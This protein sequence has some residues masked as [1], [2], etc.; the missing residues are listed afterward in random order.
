VVRVLGESGRELLRRDRESAWRLQRVLLSRLCQGAEIPEEAIG[1]WGG[2]GGKILYVMAA[3]GRIHYDCKQT[4][5]RSA[6][7]I[8][9]LKNQLQTYSAIRFNNF[10][11][12]TPRIFVTQFAASPT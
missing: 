4:N 11:L 6:I 3:S 2:G 9:F 1:I 8:P 7:T 10:S 5:K 12:E